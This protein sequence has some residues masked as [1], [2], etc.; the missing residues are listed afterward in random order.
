[1]AGQRQPI[2]LLTHKAKKHLTKA[3]IETRKRSEIHAKSDQVDPPTWLPSDLHPEFRRI[4]DE[5]LAI[6]IIANLDVEALARLISAQRRY[7][8]IEDEI[9]RQMS[10]LVGRGASKHP[11]GYTKDVQSLMRLQ[12]RVYDMCRKG[13][14]DFGLT[15]SSRCK[16]TLP[17]EPEKPD[18]PAERMYP[19]V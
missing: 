2:D 17:K 15:V 11:A 3:E 10:V 19:S 12:E 9:N 16:L 14:T 4:A 18:N 8:Q 6:G 5:L 13:A 7:I 1:M